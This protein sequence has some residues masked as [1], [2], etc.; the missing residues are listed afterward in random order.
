MTDVVIPIDVRPVLYEIP[1]YRL[2]LKEERVLY[3]A[4][5]TLEEPAATARLG[6]AE[7]GDSPHEKAIA[8]FLNPN[9]TI[10]GLMLLATSS[11]T[12]FIG[13]VSQKGLCQAALTANATSVVLVHNHPSGLAVPSREDI[14]A[15]DNIDAALEVLGI[16]LL[17]HVIITPNPKVWCSRSEEGQLWE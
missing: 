5:R 15:T 3:T 9:F 4:E 8:I 14:L 17:D 13:A 6:F 2:V 10:I 7:L 11:A 16:K 1:M 12:S